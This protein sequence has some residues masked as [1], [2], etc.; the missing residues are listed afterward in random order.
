MLRS[1]TEVMAFAPTAKIDADQPTDD[2][3]RAPLSDAS[4]FER[5]G[6]TEYGHY[7]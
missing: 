7:R 4:L 3:S 6:C 5:W 1:L 2:V